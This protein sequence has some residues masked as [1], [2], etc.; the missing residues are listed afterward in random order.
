MVRKLFIFIACIPLLGIAQQTSSLSHFYENK[1]V[2]NP[3]SVGVNQNTMLRLNARQQWYNFSEENIGTSNFTLTKGINNDG[4]GFHLF[5]D[6]SGNISRSGASISYSRKVMFSSQS[7]VYFGISGGYQNN[8]IKNIS[9]LDFGTVKDQYTWSPS[10]SF[11]VTFEHK[12]L[13][14]GLSVDGLLES[15]LGFTD[16]ENIL[17]KQYYSYITFAH[18]LSASIM[19]NPAFL[20]KYTES[21]SSQ[22]DM[23][24]NFSYKEVL[25]LGFGYKGNFNEFSDFGPLVTLGLNFNNLK[26]LI[27]QEFNTNEISSYSA[28]T[29][30]LTFVYEV[31]KQKPVKRELEQEKEVEVVKKDTDKDGI[32]DEDDQCP[33]VF[34]AKSANGCPDID[35]DG[36]QDSVDQCPNTNG[37]ILNNGCPILNESDRIVL[38]KAM[39]NLE[40][41]VASAEINSSSKKYLIN[42]AKLLLGNKNMILI[43]SGHTDSDATNE[44][45]FSLSAKR[46]KSVRDYLINMGV[47]K[48]RMVMDFYG[49]EKPL[50]PNTSELNKQKNRRVEFGIT[51]I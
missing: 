37:D 2:F 25:S 13:Q 45:N 11:G 4:I 23:N 29:T 31:F 49:E 34:G 35:Q 12:T 48:S 10:S 47:P 42:M 33:N 6:N 44:F 8:Q 36:I 7:N 9:L 3:S 18:P 50:V 1:S 21:R 19:M 16:T 43:I 30:E 39:I 51:F 40:F 28:G 38:E 46:A 15:D 22:M 20:L 24:I 41:E 5:T 32:P 26:S 14:I 17:E 27:S